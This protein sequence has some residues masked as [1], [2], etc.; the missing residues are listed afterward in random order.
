MVFHETTLHT[1]TFLRSLYYI[2]NVFEIVSFS[3]KFAKADD[4]IK[5]NNNKT[6]ATLFKMSSIV[7]I[8]TEFKQWF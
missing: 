2:I 5:W 8:L 4:K 1:H 7:S 6:S 3:K